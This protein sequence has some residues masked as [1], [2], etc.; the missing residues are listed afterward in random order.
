VGNFASLPG[1]EAFVQEFDGNS[2]IFSQ[3]TG[4]ARGLVCH[5]SCFARDVKGMPHYDQA[6]FVCP[7]NLAETREI[8]FAI[9]AQ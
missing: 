5:V 3:A 9:G 2:Q 1:G 6:D 8:F 7:A 4:E